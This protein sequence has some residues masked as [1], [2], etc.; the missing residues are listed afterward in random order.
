MFAVWKANMQPFYFLC[1]RSL[2]MARCRLLLFLALLSLGFIWTFSN[3]FEER[4][5]FFEKNTS[6]LLET[7]CSFCFFYSDSANVCE[8]QLKT[9]SQGILDD[10]WRETERE[11]V[12]PVLNY[13]E[14]LGRA[15]WIQR[16]SA[17]ARR[18][19]ADSAAQFTH[20]SLSLSN[21]FSCFSLKFKN[22]V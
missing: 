2:L 3:A 4:L 19:P 10:T 11:S 6:H 20:R 18:K 8:F 9:N 14:L 22:P 17:K 5:S 1:E 15:N 12:E 7:N 21:L 16:N 13:F